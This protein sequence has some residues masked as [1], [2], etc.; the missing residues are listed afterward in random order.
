MEK[1]ISIAPFLWW[2][3]TETKPDFTITQGKGRQGIIIR[4]RSANYTQRITR[5]IKS[6]I[7]GN[8]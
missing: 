7:R 8:A 4:T 1:T 2:H 3:Q 6:V 5:S